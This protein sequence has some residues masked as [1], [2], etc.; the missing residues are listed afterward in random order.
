MD[1]KFGIKL[2][3]CM[4]L[5]IIKKIFKQFMHMLIWMH[6]ADAQNMHTAFGWCNDN[7]N[8]D[9]C[10]K[11][12]VA[13]YPGP[14]DGHGLWLSLISSSIGNMCICSVNCWFLFL[15]VTFQFEIK[16]ALIIEWYFK[17]LFIIFDN[18]LILV[19]YWP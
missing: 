10:N 8:D 6:T 13:K 12:C 2:V 1:T 19:T 4:P 11:N 18:F 9:C 15:L 5:T 7:C 17:F 16:I 3:T 14:L